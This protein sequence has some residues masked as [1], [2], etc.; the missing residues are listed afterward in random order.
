MSKQLKVTEKL[1]NVQEFPRAA[2]TVL[3]DLLEKHNQLVQELEEL[4][5]IVRQI[6]SGHRHEI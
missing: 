2:T 5:S 6:G 1:P 4:K 3:R